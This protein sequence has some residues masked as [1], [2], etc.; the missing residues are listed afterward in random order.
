VTAA[1]GALIS[2]TD[3]PVGPYHE[4]IG[5]VTGRRGLR[6]VVH[7]PF[8]AVDSLASV[9]G[10]R[11]N[12]ALPK[13]L[14]IFTGEPRDGSAMRVTGDPADGSTW[15]IAATPARFGPWLPFAAPALASVVQ[16]GPDGDLW[17]SFSTAHGRI[18]PA[19]VDVD[20]DAASFA[21]WFPS[22]RCWG[23]A[24][25]FTGNFRAPQRV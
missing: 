24:A 19:R 14:A 9:V 15:S 12:W 22:G 6:T 17:R 23:L 4:V 8:I 13:T 7:V 20:V 21:E 3:T 16:V 10:G 1:A 18:R 11:A 25:T 5:L 2:Y